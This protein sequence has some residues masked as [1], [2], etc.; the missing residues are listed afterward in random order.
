M[1]LPFVFI[2]FFLAFV[3]ALPASKGPGVKP[4]P[5]VARRSLYARGR[6]GVQSQL[7]SDCLAGARVAILKSLSDNSSMATMDLSNSNFTSACINDVLNIMVTQLAL[8][9]DPNATDIP[10]SGDP[11]S[12]ASFDDPDVTASSVQPAT[13]APITS[14]LG[15][16]LEAQAPAAKLINGCPAPKNSVP[17]LPVFHPLQASSR[18]IKLNP[19]GRGTFDVVDDAEDEHEDPVTPTSEYDDG[20]IVARQSVPANTCNFILNNPYLSCM[21][22]TYLRSQGL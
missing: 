13:S 11:N 8:E 21:I 2:L 6:G 20:T 18:P 14:G 16:D 12:S 1:L 7:S 5:T 10:I 4:T 22:A 17:R 15:N 3:G 19:P 9:L